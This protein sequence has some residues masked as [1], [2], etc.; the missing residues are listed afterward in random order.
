MLGALVWYKARSVLRAHKIWRYCKKF[1]R[2][3]DLVPGI[4]APP[5]E[6]HS[7]AYVP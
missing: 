1:I 3:G 4:Y 7:R 6:A 2:P 5:N